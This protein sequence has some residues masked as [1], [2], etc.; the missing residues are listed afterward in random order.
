MVVEQ[1]EGQFTS[2]R[3]NSEKYTTFSV[4]IEQEVR[5]FDEKGKEIQNVNK[6]S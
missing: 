2:L 6:M 1:F 5:R 4:P 3:E